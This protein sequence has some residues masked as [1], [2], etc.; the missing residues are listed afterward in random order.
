MFYFMIFLWKGIPV[1]YTHIV[2]YIQ[3]IQENYDQLDNQAKLISLKYSNFKEYSLSFEY[4]LSNLQQKMES[5]FDQQKALMIE[6]NN[7]YIV[8]LEKNFEI[9]LQSLWNEARKE[10]YQ[11]MIQKLDHK[12]RNI[13]KKSSNKLKVHGLEINL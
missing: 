10:V 3:N 5:E 13:L 4:Y 8:M 1:I 2:T 11:E 7:Q 6:Q 12:T 9:Q